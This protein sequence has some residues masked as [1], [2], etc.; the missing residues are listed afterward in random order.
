MPQPSRSIAAICAEAAVLNTKYA[1]A[2]HTG[3]TTVPGVQ[4]EQIL[5]ALDEFMESVRYLN[6]RRSETTLALTSEAAVQDAIYL[7]LRPWLPDLVP[8][9][10]TDR[11]A[12]RYTIKDFV[13]ASAHCIIEAKFIRDREHGRAISREIHD[14]IETYR[15]DLR[16]EH[17]IF[18]VFDPDVHIPDRNALRR[19]IETARTYDGRA[20]TC[21]LIL[22]P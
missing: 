12:S 3:R 2:S 8:E 10:P 11:I 20:L 13:S 7:M 21:K 15:H 14:D 19:Q 18:F 16:C 4:V 1:R 9:S 22:K 6:T 5:A 17:L